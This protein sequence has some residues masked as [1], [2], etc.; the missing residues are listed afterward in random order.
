MFERQIQDISD[1]IFISDPPAKSDIIFLPGG[2]SW[3]LPERAARL[4]QLG[5]AKYILPSGKHT[6]QLTCFP[7]EKVT[8]L[9][10]KGEHK[11]ECDYY[12]SI[13][14][15]N[16]VPAQSIIKEPE[17][18]NTL[19]NA[20]FSKAAIENRHIQVSKAI[21]VCKSYHARRVLLTYSLC[22]PSI[23]FFVCPVDA[24]NISKDNWYKT[25]LGIQRVLGE[26]E[27]CGKYFVD[28]LQKQLL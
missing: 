21:I 2:A 1:F 12:S 22:L 15:L 13:L 14:A 11:T 28:F 10:Y 20:L 18:T 25:S 9:R 24:Q 26:V 5:H 23:D 7:N 6:P 19:E 8:N 17:A 16:G 4:Y 3:A 27:R